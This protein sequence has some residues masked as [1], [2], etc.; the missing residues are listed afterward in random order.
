MIIVGRYDTPTS[1]TT[2][3]TGLAFSK[4]VEYKY[5]PQLSDSANLKY[6]FL[7]KLWA[8]SK[9]DDLLVKYYINSNNARLA[10][11]LK[12]V[13]T[14]TSLAYGVLSPFTSFQ[15]SNPDVTSIRELFRPAPD[16]QRSANGIISLVSAYPNPF[17]TQSKIVFSV[18]EAVYGKSQIRVINSAG[19]II[20]S[21]VIEICG[22][23]NYEYDLNAANLQL[24]NESQLFV[25]I[26]VNGEVLMVKMICVRN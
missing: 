2:T 7:P 13:I 10:D 12:K 3:L 4:Q 20:C 8:K 18:N 14:Y 1:V 24:A 23:G 6:Q 16:E 25:V 5:N 26:E 15:G 19:V 9:I 21:D 11:S 22:E 17:T